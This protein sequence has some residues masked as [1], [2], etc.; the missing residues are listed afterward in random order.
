MSENDKDETVYYEEKFFM[1]MPTNDSGDRQI[2]STTTTCTKDITRGDDSDAQGL[3]I[4]GGD[5]ATESSCK[6][7]GHVCTD[8]SIC[9]TQDNDELTQSSKPNVDTIERDTL[10]CAL[11]LCSPDLALLESSFKIEEG[12]RKNTYRATNGSILT[13]ISQDKTSIWRSESG[14]RC[15]L[16]QHYVKGESSLLALYI[17]NGIIP[18]HRF[19]EKNADGEWKRLLEND[20]FAKLAEMKRGTN[21]LVAQQDS[22][23]P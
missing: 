2:L 7:E 22:S 15:I 4:Y 1:E 6:R 21:G 20:F 12:V 3:A 17:D 13:S 18:E 5:V 8:D 23:G 10:E 19:F 16:V 9:S 14:E 11:D